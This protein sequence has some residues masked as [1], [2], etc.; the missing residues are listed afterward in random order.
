[1]D[2][3]IRDQQ[4]TVVPQFKVRTNVRGGASTG[5]TVAGVYYPDNSGVCSTS[6]TP[7][8]SGTGAGWVS[9]VYYPDNSGVCGGSGT[10]L[11]PTTTPP[12]TGTTP[13]STGGGNVGGVW[14]PD[15]SG[16]CV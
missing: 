6:T 7:P 3:N 12:P 16:T 9:G 11:P 1:M 4:L 2:T 10:P 15:K 5:G 13:P 8:S 14:Y